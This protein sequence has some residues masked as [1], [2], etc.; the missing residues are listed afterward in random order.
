M[1]NRRFQ[2]GRVLY[3]SYLIGGQTPSYSSGVRSYTEDLIGAESS[4][5]GGCG[6][7]CDCDS[8]SSIFPILAAIGL[9]TLFLANVIRDALE[10]DDDDDGTS[11]NNGR[12]FIIKKKRRKRSFGQSANSYLD[13]L[14]NSVLDGEI[15]QYS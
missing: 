1:P 12:I 14:T 4:Y 7:G 5:G 11:G 8:G 9:A 2:S 6:C 13:R 3:P 10:E 15:L